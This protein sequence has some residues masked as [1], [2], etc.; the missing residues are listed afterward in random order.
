M[1]LHLI[2]HGRTI[3]NEN[4]L[5]CGVTDI[6]VSD[7]GLTELVTL[8]NNEDVEY[9]ANADL[10]VVSGLLRT[11]MTAEVL[12]G[13]SDCKVM[14]ELREFDF[15]EFEMCT[16]DELVDQK[17]YQDWISDLDTVCVPNGESKQDFICRVVTGVQKIET[18]GV[19][20][21]VLITHG[22]VIATIMDFY[23]PGNKNFY[24]WQPDCGRG[25]TIQIE[26][27]NRFYQKI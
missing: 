24:E 16:H 14:E 26:D 18:L 27:E 22:G 15:G 3:A 8:K 4:R 20:N 9:P 23:F 12:F 25:Y 2:R 1:I 11:V 13:H 7:K 19:S 17:A 10:Y 21:V 6:P 5:Y